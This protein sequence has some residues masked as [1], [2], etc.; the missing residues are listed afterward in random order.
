MWQSWSH[1]RILVLLLALSFSLGLTYLIVVPPWQAPDE[2][3]HFEHARLLYEKRRFVDYPDI[4]SDLEREIIAS[5]ER[6]NFWAKGAKDFDPAEWG[7]LPE[8]FA[9]VWARGTAHELHQGPLAYVLYAL[10][11]PMTISS[12]TE[13]QLY[14]MRFLSILL[15]LA[16][17]CLAFI[18]V[19]ELFPNRDFLNL[20]VPAFILLL[21]QH[22]FIHSVVNNDALAE[23]VVSLVILVLVRVFK[24]GFSISRLVALLGLVVVGAFTKK[25]TLFAV[26]L[27][28]LAAV[29]Y[30]L[31]RIRHR[32]FRLSVIAASVVVV[33]GGIY[34]RNTLR[35]L[36]VETLPGIYYN[37][38]GLWR[39]A[40]Q[41]PLQLDPFSTQ[42]VTAYRRWILVTF[43]SFWAFFGWMNL[44]LDLT[45]YAF[46]G[47]IS[48]VA[49]AGLILLF[50]RLSRGRFALADWQLMTLLVFWSA[51]L[52]ASIPVVVRQFRDF[53]GFPQGRYL[54]P[55]LVPLATFFILGLE[56][57]IPAHRQR[58]A[59]ALCIL[60]L[61]VLN[62]VSI[63]GSIIPF[64]AS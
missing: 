32:S 38:F 12:S 18:T 11:L 28:L 48:L 39:P 34:G 41:E 26:P 2:P 44:R 31:W 47:V 49:A 57:W 35:D 23:L 7:R 17:G 60:G 6:R 62:V 20:S 9:E 3:A 46:L 56:Q 16:G 24:Y 61:S 10:T 25:S 13:T 33:A 50:L 53:E 8:S 59:L 29:I 64:Y 54:F 36:L 19:R 51:I 14:V 27:L 63:I 42:A 1:R 15:G 4:S 52:L 5:M 21:P 22:L 43:E 30:L 37:Y 40:G 58:V 55:V 45:W